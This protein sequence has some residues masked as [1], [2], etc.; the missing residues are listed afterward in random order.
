MNGVTAP[1]GSIHALDS[2]GPIGTLSL[3]QARSGFAS[4]MSRF[5]LPLDT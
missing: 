3:A 5:G 2:G 1:I 4:W